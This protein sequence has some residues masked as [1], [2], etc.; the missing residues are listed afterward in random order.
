MFAGRG[1]GKGQLRTCVRGEAR[2]LS[3]TRRHVGKGSNCTETCRLCFSQPDE[4]LPGLSL[5]LFRC[6][7]RMRWFGSCCIPKRFVCDENAVGTTEPEG[8]T[9]HSSMSP[10]PV[11]RQKVLFVC[12]PGGLHENRF[13][14]YRSGHSALGGYLCRRLWCVHTLPVPVAVL[15]QTKHSHARWNETRLC[16]QTDGRCGSK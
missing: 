13:I 5:A 2:S 15:R 16:L 6:P 4:L 7:H 3:R 11:C 1:R 9:P 12:F 10:V 14:S 8:L